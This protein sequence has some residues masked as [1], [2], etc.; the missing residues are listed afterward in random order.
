MN[1]LVNS[2][3]IPAGSYPYTA[4]IEDVH[5]FDTTVHSGSVTISQADIGTLGGNTSIHTQ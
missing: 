3:S 2:T 1:L 5:G 4:S